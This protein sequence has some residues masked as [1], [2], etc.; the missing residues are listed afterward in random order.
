MNL[1]P[2][3]TKL[4]SVSVIRN[5]TTE[6]ELSLKKIVDDSIGEG[7]ILGFNQSLKNYLKVS[8]RNTDYVPNK[9]DRTET[10]GTTLRKVLTQEVS[11]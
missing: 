10:T 9:Y 3:V 7:S 5:P 2:K 6:N 1:I 11:C 8:I 4:D